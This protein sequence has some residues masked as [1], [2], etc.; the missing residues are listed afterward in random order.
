MTSFDAYGHGSERW[1][2]I[3]ATPPLIDVAGVVTAYYTHVP[4]PGVA[5]QRVQFGTA[6]H[7]GTATLSSFNEWHVQAIAQAICRFRKARSIDGP[8]FLGMDTHALS[9]PACASTLEVLA[10]NGVNVMLSAGDEYT[11]TPA[12]SHAILAYNHGRTTGLAD[13]IVVT[14]SHNPPGDGGIKYNATH[15]GPADKV[16]T[17]WIQAIAN[18]Y[19]EHRLAG[20]QRI[21]HAQALRAATTHRHDY[22][23]TYVRDLGNVIDMPVIAASGLR[24]GVD[25]LGGAGVHY[26]REIAARY[27]LDLRVLDETVDPRFA[28]IAPDHDGQI[29]MDPSSPQAMHRLLDARSDIDIAF[30]CDPDHDRHGIV[31]PG[32]G[33]LPPNHYLSVVTDYLLQQRTAWSA[34]VL[35]GKSVVTSTMIDRVAA[36]HRH[37][38]F[39][40]PVGFKWFADGLQDGSL[41]LACE[42]SAGASFLRMDGT[43]WTSDKDGIAAGLLA[44]EITARTG[45]DP[46]RRY[47]ALERAFGQPVAARVEMPATAEQRRRLAA[48]T[49]QDVGMEFLAGHRIT[50]VHT[51]AKGNEQ[52]IGGLKVESAGAWFVA[53][54]SG[55]EAMYRIYAE[56]LHGPEHLMEVLE[57]ARTIVD[58]ATHTRP[59]TPVGRGIP[60]ATY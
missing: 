37:G 33:L 29:R 13:G 32:A 44:A 24:I 57:V 8:L 38:V 36:H 9:H 17:D 41:G 6:G 21:A 19:L 7:R 39:E 46:G 15:G 28:F 4:D 20:V 49:A 53:R 56:T 14:P 51:R 58:T 22:L 34:R 59:S 26:W 43:V 47:L 54:P 1:R 12:V 10:A 23:D 27:H 2:R 52:P 60:D 30:G 40:T 16:V 3:A 55:T 25:P 35:V 50:G 5:A 42:E 48:L 31:T 45:R 18:Q 11:P